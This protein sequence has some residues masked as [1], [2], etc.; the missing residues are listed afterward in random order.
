MAKV[1]EERRK[2]ALR[3]VLV[4]VMLDEMKIKRHIDRNGKCFVGYVD[5]R[6]GITT[7]SNPPGTYALVFQAVSVGQSWKLPLGYFMVAGMAGEEK[8]NFLKI[9]LQ[10]LAKV[11]VR[12]VSVTFNSARPLICHGRPG[13]LAHELGASFNIKD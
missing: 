12:A 5:T 8:A 1:E 11:R 10:K 2:G 7:D 13:Q 9:C 4:A 3:E 6:C